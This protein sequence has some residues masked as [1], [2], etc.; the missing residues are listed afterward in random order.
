MGLFGSDK[1]ER[2]E[3]TIGLSEEKE[4]DSSEESDTSPE[5]GAIN[6]DSDDSSS[7]EDS[8][9]LRDEVSRLDSVKDSSSDTSSSSESPDLEEIQRQNQKI[10]EKLDTVLSRL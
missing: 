10:I 8:G 7:E 2:E 4:E 3:V 9:N 6:F 1:E 5:V